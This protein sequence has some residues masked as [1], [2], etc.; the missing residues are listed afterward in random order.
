[1]N[2]VNDVR[3]EVSKMTPPPLHSLHFLELYDS[4]RGL[5]TYLE[6]PLV[7]GELMVNT[8]GHSGH[9]QV[10][11]SLHCRNLEII[12]ELNPLNT[13]EIT[14]SNVCYYKILPVEYQ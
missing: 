10:P 7:A 14:S 3:S 6:L 9:P 5:N 11:S 12:F 13:S 2:F 8:A 4:T 1:M